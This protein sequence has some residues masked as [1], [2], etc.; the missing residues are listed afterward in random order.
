MTK[1]VKTNIIEYLTQSIATFNQLVNYFKNAANHTNQEICSQRASE[2]ATVIKYISVSDDVVNGDLVT[3]NN[4]T[5]N[6]FLCDPK[7]YPQPNI[8]GDV[9][10]YNFTKEK[11]KN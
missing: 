5:I 4:T 6:Y 3:N 2:L 8:N 9:K 7:D 10:I 1:E 11:K